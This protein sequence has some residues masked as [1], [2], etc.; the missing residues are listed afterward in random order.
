MNRSTPKLAATL[1]SIPPGKLEASRKRVS[2]EIQHQQGE[3][4]EAPS[5]TAHLLAADRFTQGLDVV[6]DVL[7]LLVGRFQKT[8]TLLVLG[9]ILQLMCVVALV[10]ATIGL[11]SVKEKV[12]LLQAKQEEFAKS[13][14]RLEKTTTETQKKVETTE[15]KVDDAA[16]K[17]DEQP[18]LSVVEDSKGKPKVIIQATKVPSAK[19]SAV[20]PVAASASPTQAVE[21]PAKPIS[22]PPL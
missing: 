10:G 22:A 15:K 16:T 7:I 20:P 3:E 4:A 9:G 21:I 14:Q 8:T 12:E 19:P 13:Q 6:S 5:S 11:N 1:T 2:E 18:K 17:F